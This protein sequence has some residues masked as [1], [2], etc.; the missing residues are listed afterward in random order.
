MVYEAKSFPLLAGACRNWRSL[1]GLGRP[2]LSL[3][4][5]KPVCLRV[6]PVDG[7]LLP[8]LW[9]NPDSDCAGPGRY[10]RCTAISYAACTDIGTGECI[11]AESD[12][13]ADPWKKMVGSALPCMVAGSSRKP[14]FGKL[15]GSKYPLGGI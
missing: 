3:S 5:W 2:I 13:V 1:G 9:R 4:L 10:S 15:L 14:V 7:P 11:S 6:L 8:R 12:S